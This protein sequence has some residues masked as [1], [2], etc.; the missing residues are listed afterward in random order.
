VV[1]MK[2]I[3][4]GIIGVG[5]CASGLIQGIEYYKR[6]PK[7]EPIGLMH[8]EIGGYSFDSIVVTAAWDIGN[9]KVGKPLNEAFMAEPNFVKW[10]DPPKSDVIVQEAP[11]LDSVSRY[12]KRWINPVRQAK[13]PSTLKREILAEIERSGAEILINYLPVGSARA[14]KFWAQVSLDSGCGFVN[15]IPEFIASDR[16]W[17]N[18]FKKAG[19]PACGDDIKSQIGATIVHRVLCKLCTDRG[20]MIDRT[21]QLNVG[22]NTDFANMLDRG[23]LKS[24]E[25]SKT[26][27]VQSQLRERMQAENIHIGPSDFIPFLGNTKVAFMRIE[28]RMYA[29]IPFNLEVRLEVD[30][31]A[32]SGGV[33]IDAIRCVKLAMDRGIG[34]PLIAPSAYFMKHPPVQFSDAEARELVEKFIGGDGWEPQPSMTSQDR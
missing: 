21:Y 24:K 22:G 3:R 7:Q 26:E 18:K 10:V 15:C 13:D 27:A 28:G 14:T 2:D 4:I 8:R 23:R 12:T 20:A 34:G 17:G 19:V 6:N 25:I 31:K 32:N 16:V 9:N 11:I 30:D 1:E 29:N 5:N 33:A